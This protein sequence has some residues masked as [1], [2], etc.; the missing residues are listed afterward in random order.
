MN[1]PKYFFSLLILCFLVSN[2]NA[3]ITY[4]WQNSKQG[5]VSGVGCTLTA[6]PSAL[7]MRS[8]NTTPFMRSG[9]LQDDLGIDAS[10]YNVVEVTLKN[11][12]TTPGN[13]NGRLFVYPPGSNT[14]MCNY[15][16]LV[17]TS[18]MVFLPTQ[19]I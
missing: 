16:F 6:Q 10:D 4:N 9:S 18:M 1:F 2:F 3:Q 15:N 11:P 5:W 17:D 12:T 19:F 14:A 7:A 8:F 13:P